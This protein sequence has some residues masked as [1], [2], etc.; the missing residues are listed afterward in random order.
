MGVFHLPTDD[1][2]RISD[3]SAIV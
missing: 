3:C 1:L 2:F